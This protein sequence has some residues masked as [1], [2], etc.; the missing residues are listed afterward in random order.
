MPVAVPFIDLVAQYQPIKNEISAAV[1]AVLE[2]QKF[3]LGDGVSE[4]EEKLA[5][6]MGLER[7]G[8]VG[9]SSGTDA[10]LASLMALGVGPGDEVLTTPFSFFA[11]AGVIA[12][13]HAK[14]V[15]ADI[16][17]L[18]FNLD[19]TKLKDLD[20]KRFKAVV[21]VHLFGRLADMS[22][23]RA[24]ADPQGV[25]IVEDAAQG[26]GV[27]DQHGQHCGTQG[28]VGCFSFFPTKNLGGAGDGGCVVTTDPEF[29]ASLRQIRVHG[30]VRAYESQ[31][32]GGNF[33][34]DA[35]QAAILQVKLAHLESWGKARLKNARSYDR[36]LREKGLAEHLQLPELPEN[37]EFVAHQYVVRSD[38][39]DALKAF[40]TKNQIA[41]AIYY[42]VPFHLMPCFAGLGHKTGDFPV[43]EL[44]SHEVLALPVFPE[45]GEERLERVVA[46]I[47]AFYEQGNSRSVND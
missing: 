33:R 25:P 23:L 3:I 38:R 4:F 7:G 19:A 18:S 42:P 15:F 13:L 21:V 32:I 8:V 14:P 27:R 16:D 34:L 30:A 22:G 29:L 28:K 41:S 45:L 1:T 24:W 11:T 36:R 20:A 17:P 46:V 47:S 39:R 26:I 10:L 2:S 12:R 40:L 35:I 37:E 31:I 5:S 6:W 9:V 44:A 43:A